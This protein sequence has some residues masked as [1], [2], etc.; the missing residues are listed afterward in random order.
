MVNEVLVVA[1][2]SFHLGSHVG[3]GRARGTISGTLFHTCS[4]VSTMACKVEILGQEAVDADEE[5][6]HEEAGY[7]NSVPPSHRE[8]WWT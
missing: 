8:Y 2:G 5:E 3:L 1:L 7:P 6:G 4:R